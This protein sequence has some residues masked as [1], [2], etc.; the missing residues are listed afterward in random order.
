MLFFDSVPSGR[1]LNR[2]S[3]DL[4]VIDAE[5]PLTL[6]YSTALGLTV[7]SQSFSNHLEYCP[8]PLPFLSEVHFGARIQVIGSITIT[9]MAVPIILVP[10]LPLCILFARFRRRFL[11]TSRQLKRLEAVARSPIF[12]H[13]AENLPGLLRGSEKAVRMPCMRSFHE[14]V[15]TICTDGW[16]VA[17]QAWRPS[18]QAAMQLRCSENS[19]AAL[20]RTRVRP[21]ERCTLTDRYPRNDD[22]S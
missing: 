21:E 19:C 14:C 17:L 1:V 6:Y 9:V 12:S 11:K 22:S 16:F 8:R 5:L 10:L 20:R 4:G 18:A 15:L 13:F 3:Q 2:F 7:L